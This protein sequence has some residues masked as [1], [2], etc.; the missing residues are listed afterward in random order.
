MTASVRSH[1]VTSGTGTTIAAAVPAVVSAGDH[2]WAIHVT[3]TAPA[4]MTAAGWTLAGSID[5]FL[6]AKV[7]R[8]TATSAEPSSYAF[9]QANLSDGHVFMLAVADVDVSLPPVLV[10]GDSFGIPT[11]TPGVTPSGAPH[12]EIRVAAVALPGQPIT[13]QIPPGFTS[14][15]ASESALELVAAAAASRLINSSAASGEQLFTALP[16]LGRDG[17]G[18]T[19]S[20]PSAAAREP[21]IPTFPAFTPTRGSARYQYRFRRLR[22]G[23][24]LGHLDLADVSFDKRI[25][26]PG[27]F[28]A[29]IPIPSRRVG[30]QVAEVVG[31]DPS[32]IDTGPGVMVVDIIRDGDI[33]G[34]YW[35]TSSRLDRGQSG[36]PKIVLQGTTLDG[37]MTAVEFQT[38][39][40]F[41][42]EDQIDIA[43]AL[44]ANLQAQ[45]YANI[46]LTVA[47]GTCGVLRDRTY[48]DDGGTYG[49]RLRELAELNNGFEYSIDIAAAGGTIVRQLRWGYPRLGTGVVEHVFAL[50]PN[51]GELIAYGEDNDVLRGATRYRARGGTLPGDASTT[52]A[53]L[54]STVHEATLLLEAG[55]P[56]VDR[57]LSYSDVTVAQTLD[58]YAAHWAA[59]APGAVRVEQYT[60]AL[61][62]NPSIHP[63]LLGDTC[64]LYLDDEW[65]RGV[66]RERRIIGL[67]I[68]PESRTGK[69]EAKLI[70]EQPGEA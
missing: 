13:W 70:L 53:P 37:W 45:Q 4:S 61:G 40:L 35:I 7:W 56:R 41:E 69:E 9:G 26:S 66:T 51:G 12:L 65:Y 30:D 16:Q 33:W 54:M 28:S 42:Q 14:R 25:S 27:T 5:G 29:T 20:L 6:A 67:A 64:R 68:T 8:R 36:T 50:G 1:T 58:D 3:D 23:Q 22:D 11:S 34:E 32:Q 2:L 17:I 63:N 52:S 10:G 39:L 48:T 47:A 46:G 62:A 43:R 44:I 18:L 38:E 15:G 59:I 19:I 55:W 60:V 49:Q 24:Y 21:E 57:T 31:R